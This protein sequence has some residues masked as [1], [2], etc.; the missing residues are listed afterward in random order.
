MKHKLSIQKRLI[1]PV[2]LLGIVALISNILS[3][4]SIHNVNANA[5]NIVDNYM[6]GEAMLAGIHQSVM[7]IH[8]LA[9]SH[10]VAT[11]YST[12]IKVVG[13]IKEEERG[14]DI[15][16]AEY[17]TYVI[18]TASYQE[19]LENYDSFKDSLIRLVCASADSKTQDAYALA[20]GDVARFA[21]AI[22]RNIDD[23]YE[24][25]TSRAANARTRLMAVYI[26]SLIISALSIVTGILLILAAL[27]IKIGRAHV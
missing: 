14:L 23:L 18:R 10:I 5:A 3:I 26:T 21:E 2:V 27:R 16:M 12:M 6:V 1:L 4:F 19:L 24:S 9:L 22:E 20:N 13:Q 8:K 7:N 25:I 17:E 11:D 15:Q